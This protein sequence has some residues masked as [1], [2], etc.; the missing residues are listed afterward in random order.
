VA[1]FASVKASSVCI[2]LSC[3]VCIQSVVHGI[4]S[5]LVC[6]HKGCSLYRTKMNITSATGGKKTVKITE[7]CGYNTACYEWLCVTMMRII[8]QFVAKCVNKYD[9]HVGPCVSTKKY[10]KL[11]RS[12]FSY[13]LMP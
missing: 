8:Q 3:L 7:K 9:I 5:R 1:F 6:S 11:D 12:G 4:W 2:C 10:Q 13:R